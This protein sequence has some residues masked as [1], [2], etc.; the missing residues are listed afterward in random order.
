MGRKQTVEKNPK[1]QPERKSL[2]TRLHVVLL[3]IILILI[4]VFLLSTYY[5]I[6]K[7][8]REYEIREAESILNSVSGNILSNVKNYKG[9]S[10]LIMLDDQLVEFL[11]ADADVISNS[12]TNDVHSSILKI[13]TATSNVDS[14]IVLREDMI[15]TYADEKGDWK[16][17]GTKRG[18]YTYDYARM[19]SD[20]WKEK[21][22]RG[23]GSA[24]F[25]ING[26]GAI[27]KE[28]G[29]P[30]LTIARSVYDLLSQQRTGIL[31]INISKNM[32]EW[33]I[34]DMYRDD[35][36]IMGTDGT[37][38]AGN[39]ELSKYFSDISPSE[40]MMH[41]AR[42]EGGERILISSCTIGDLPLVVI[43]VSHAEAASA[44][45]GSG[46]VLLF[47][48]IVCMFAVLMA[49]L[50]ITKNI[51][52]PVFE[53]TNAMEE[54]KESGKLEKIHLKMPNNELHMI[55]ESYNN[56]IGHVND[57][58]KRLIENEKTIQKAEMRVLHEQI[59]PHFLYNSLETIGFLAMDA[60]AEKVYSA[61]ETLGSFY[62]IFLSKGDREIPLHKE[63]TIVRDYLVLQKLRYGDII[64][65]EYDLADDT[66][67]CIVP[68]LILQPLVENSIYHGIRQKGEKGTIKISSRC[69]N[70]NLHLYILD[71]GVGMSQEQIDKVMNAETDIASPE[72]GEQSESFGLWGTIERIRC[73][74]DSDE[75]VRI[76]SE[77]GEYTEIEFIIPQKDDQRS[78]N[79]QSYDH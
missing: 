24:T 41:R 70:G 35:V 13:L 56:M 12:M 78:K 22:W 49:G 15:V 38:F 25:S 4:I 48:L 42:Y 11:R 61:L 59:K 72:A 57:L 68:K 69:N 33:T 58:I 77:V 3:G 66:L 40:S 45:R 31:L 20:Q 8:R 9:L 6:E 65:D 50:F 55:E 53:L 34:D 37:F 51:T 21:I 64:E 39:E 73:F 44:S 60:G 79:V 1:S 67:D 76:R 19:S 17:V 46:Y 7:E 52:D 36:C 29:E 32:M 14:V 47:L 63:I 28:N 71:T 75:V 54:N 74:C 10:R 2:S 27:T 5:I 16:V 18:G 23:K 43:H 26:D 62:R 30:V